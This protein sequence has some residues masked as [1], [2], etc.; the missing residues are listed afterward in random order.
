[1]KSNWASLPKSVQAG[2]SHKDAGKFIPKVVITDSQTNKNLLSI[3]YEDW[4]NE[5]KTM[6]KVDSYFEAIE[7]EKSDEQDKKLAEKRKYYSWKNFEGK[8]IQAQFVQL[9]NQTVTLKMRS[10]KTVNYALDKLNTES[11]ALAKSIKN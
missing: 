10:G 11:Q 1:M 8:I 4:K 3:R 9:S 6:K 5:S 7:K 2:L